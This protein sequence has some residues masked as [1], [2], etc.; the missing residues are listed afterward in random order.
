MI[1][2]LVVSVTPKN[3]LHGIDLVHGKKEGGLAHL[4]EGEDHAL[5]IK[6]GGL[7]PVSVGGHVLVNG[8]GTHVHILTKG[9]DH[10]LMREEDVQ[11][12]ALVKRDR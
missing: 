1:N 12:H 11:G 7:I 4:R 6:E 10:N 2:L 8:G 3:I 5:E 9:E